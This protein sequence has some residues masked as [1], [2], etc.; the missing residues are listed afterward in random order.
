MPENK[1]IQVVYCLLCSSPAS[2]FYKPTFRNAVSLPHMKMKRHTVFRTSAYKIQTPGNYT[3]DNI[4]HP[5][6]CE[7][8]KTTRTCK[9]INNSVRHIRF[10][11]GESHCVSPK[12]PYIFFFKVLVIFLH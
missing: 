4:L 12:P 5:Q 3:E 10:C 1:D 6:H 2:E 7:S 11:E 8:L 9:L